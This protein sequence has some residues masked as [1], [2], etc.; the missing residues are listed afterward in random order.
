M[1]WFS[2]A[3]RLYDESVPKPDF[4]ALL[5]S[6]QAT[7]FRD[8]AETRISATVPVSERLINELVA[9]TMPPTVPLREVHVHP[10]AGDAFAVRLSPRAAFL[11]SLTVRLTID[12][13]PSLPGSPVLVLRMATMGGLFGLA[14]GALPIAQMLPP[15]VR[16]EGD[17]IHVDLQAIAAQRGFSE[18]LRYVRELRV[19]TEERRAVLH[20]LAAV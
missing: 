3:T 5:R 20:L 8:L 9:G 16:L 11:P 19:T 13:Q 2:A 7:E 12:R 1:R 15:G 4:P 10:E 14:A 17:L 18:M 6:L